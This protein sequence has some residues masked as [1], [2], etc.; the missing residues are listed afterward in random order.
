M[1]PTIAQAI[2][3]PI[4]TAVMLFAGWRIM[5]ISIG[6]LGFIFVIL[7][8]IFYKDPKPENDYEINAIEEESKDENSSNLTWSSLFKFRSTWGMIIGAFGT[9]FTL[10]VFLTWLP[11]YLSKGRGL[12]LMTTGWV[13]SIPFIAGIFG[14]PI[15]GLLADYLIKKA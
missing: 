15:G 1:G 6:A 11:G 9:N 5:F 8:I 2:A 13:S 14:V 4:L 10:W 3:P 12:D 7:W